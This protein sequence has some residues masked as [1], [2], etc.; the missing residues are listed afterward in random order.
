MSTNRYRPPDRWSE[1]KRGPNGR[2]LCPWCGTEVKP[3]R[4]RWCS[5]KCVHEVNLRRYPQY[6]RYY[7]AR[8]DKGVCS[9]C[10]LDTRKL[11]EAA[12]K[13]AE[14]WKP[15]TTGHPYWSA[16]Q[17][18][19]KFILSRNHLWEAHHK[20]AVVEGGGECGLD[21][22]ETVCIW[23][24]GKLTGELQKR[25]NAADKDG[26]QAELPVAGKGGS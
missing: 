22:M 10:G 19:G 23:C 13:L 12:Q 25:L 16:I 9:R 11:L 5:K 2:R 17:I 21:G 24:H 8:R 6:M 1:D 26:E 3:P 4:R 15:R 20:V 7:V 18:G 14:L